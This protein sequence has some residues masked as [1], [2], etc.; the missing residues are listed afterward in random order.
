ML[1]IWKKYSF[2]MMMELECLFSHGKQWSADRV[3]LIP[4]RELVG[5]LVTAICD[6]F[7]GA[8]FQGFQVVT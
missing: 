6:R 3:G 2:K 4:I 5:M 7:A 8:R 1:D